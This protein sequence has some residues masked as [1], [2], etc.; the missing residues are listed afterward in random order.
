MYNLAFSNIAWDAAQDIEMYEILQ[1]R[2][3]MGLEI[4]PSR[5]FGDKPYTKL[6]DAEEWSKWLKSTYGI[7]V[8]SIQSIWFG[9]VENIFHT[10]SD[11]ENLIDYT[12]QAIN[13]CDKIQCTNIVF[14]CPKNRNMKNAK[15]IDIAYQFFQ[16]ISS[17]A[18]SK[19]IC[20]ALEANPPIYH[21][22]FLNDTYEVIEFVKSLGTEGLKVNLD[23]GT[24]IENGENLSAIFE[25]S[26][27]IHH[28][29]I[30]E[31]YLLLIK[32]RELHNELKN[33]IQISGY[34][35]YIS[36]E[37]GKREDIKEV[38]GIIDY[39]GKIFSE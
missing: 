14:G 25:Y 7:L 35:R 12:I 13:F 15:D 24:V 16:R 8:C 18:A 19:G 38:V 30:S 39:I 23:I 1:K 10:I 26:N 22:N 31:P 17:Y 21:T 33:L 4:A 28:I 6:S 29:H 36:I 37:M 3:F 2:N 9:R 5:V 27:L 34:E 20:I 11:R 32:R